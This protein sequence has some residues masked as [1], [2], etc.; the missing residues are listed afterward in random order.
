MD[1]HDSL[2]IARTG[3]PSFYCSKILRFL[4]MYCFLCKQPKLS[5]TTTLLHS[6]LLFNGWFVLNM[7]CVRLPIYFFLFLNV[8]YIWCCKFE[9]YL[10][11]FIK[12]IINGWD[13]YLIY[14]LS[15]VCLQFCFCMYMNF[16]HTSTH[17]K[18]HA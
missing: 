8:T 16:T 2:S 1:C 6:F 15:W 17:S 9:M 5:L 14:S 7:S 4:K 12:L 18:L 3:K 13:K 10:A 11:C